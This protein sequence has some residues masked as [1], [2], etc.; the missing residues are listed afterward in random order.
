MRYIPLEKLPYEL[1]RI[2]VPVTPAVDIGRTNVYSSNYQTILSSR[3]VIRKSHIDKLRTM[4][5][6]QV[7]VNDPLTDDIKVHNPVDD[8]MADQFGYFIDSIRKKLFPIYYELHEKRYTRATFNLRYRTHAHSF[9]CSDSRI[10]RLNQLLNDM[11]ETFQFDFRKEK[12][13]HFTN[14]IVGNDY[15][16]FHGLF[17]GFLAAKLMVESG[18]TQDQIRNV[19]V[20]TLLQDI[21]I[22][23]EYY[24][25]KK[26]THEEER[27]F[28][29]H[30]RLA[31]M[32]INETPLF[33]PLMGITA[34]NHHRY[35]NRSG[36]PRS[37]H[38][39][40]IYNYEKGMHDHGKIASIVNTYA[41][42]SIFYPP[43]KVLE[44]ISY[45]FSNFLFAQPYALLLPSVLNPY[46]VGYALELTSG[47]KVIVKENEHFDKLVVRIIYDAA[48]KRPKDKKDLT[49]YFHQNTVKGPW[50]LDE[51]LQ[52][53]VTSHYPLIILSY[54]N[55][56]M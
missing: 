11:F 51:K 24:T 40:K 9:V 27:I 53:I 19:F 8:N 31:C 15:V 20:G 54:L 23:P 33:N 18:A 7:C 2:R 21:G 44:C 35:I 46:P 36:F 6:N 29:E 14:I 22:D 26:P 4:G 16:R 50:Y 43:H 34:L 30:P 1:L 17:C 47:E 41:A 12:I 56:N 37:M 39:K 48:G 32:I 13:S 3:A 38:I 25:L 5:V 49:V 28:K 55:H 52:K 42:L 10:P 45:I